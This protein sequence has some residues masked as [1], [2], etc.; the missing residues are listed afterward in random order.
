MA[1]ISKPVGWVLVHKSPVS[2]TGSSICWQKRLVHSTTFKHYRSMVFTYIRNITVLFYGF[3][4]IDLN[5]FSCTCT[6]SSF[7]VLFHI[8]LSLKYTCTNINIEY[9][10]TDQYSLYYTQFMYR[11][12]IRER[13]SQPGTQVFPLCIHTDNMFYKYETQRVFSK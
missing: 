1:P 8:S 10:L 9:N 12:Y 6:F 3:Q 13:M 5:D 7:D 11:R 4:L 2:N